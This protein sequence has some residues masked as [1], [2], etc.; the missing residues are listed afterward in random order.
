VIFEV[1]DPLAVLF[2]MVAAVGLV[3]AVVYGKSDRR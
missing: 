3:A 1:V 2:L